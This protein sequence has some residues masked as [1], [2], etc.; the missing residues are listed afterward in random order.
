MLGAWLFSCATFAA[1]GDA[2]ATVDMQ[3]RDISVV[4][5]IETEGSFDTDRTNNFRVMPFRAVAPEPPPPPPPAPSPPPPE[6]SPAPAPSPPPPDPS[7]APTPAPATGGGG[8]GA[9]DPALLLL[10]LGCALCLP[11]LARR[12]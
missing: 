12:R 6:P 3:V 7:P 1:R 4:G 11:A 10:L 9:V 8:G 2:Q 5:F